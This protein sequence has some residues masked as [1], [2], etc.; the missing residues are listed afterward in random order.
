MGEK[1]NQPF[2]LNFNALLKVDFQGSR[3]TSDGGL[4]LVRE[5]DEHLGFG[6]LIHQHLADP[7]QEKQLRRDAR[8]WANDGGVSIAADGIE[9]V[10]W[11]PGFLTAMA[12]GQGVNVGVTL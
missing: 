4:I 6:E 2:Q 11:W 9:K 10:Y 7:G 5:L 3:V 12:H 8:Q 1:R